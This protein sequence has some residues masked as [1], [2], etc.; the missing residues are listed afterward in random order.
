MTTQEYL[1]K[2]IASI[3]KL[4]SA[5][6]DEILNNPAEY[7]FDV[8]AE[9]FY[10]I[11]D[12]QYKTVIKFDDFDAAICDGWHFDKVLNFGEKP[13]KIQLRKRIYLSGDSSL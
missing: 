3:L 1:E 6:V 7:A 2:H 11:S 10:K 9:K 8:E 13:T 4:S 12:A 5:Q